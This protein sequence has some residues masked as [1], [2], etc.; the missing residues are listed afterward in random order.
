MTHQQ[1]ALTG[2]PPGLPRRVRCRLCGSELRD[3][4]SRR[5]GFGPECDPDRRFGHRSHDVDQEPLPGL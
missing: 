2:L 3:A 1:E 5:R 4:E